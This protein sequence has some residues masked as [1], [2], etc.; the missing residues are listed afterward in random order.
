MATIQD[1]ARMSGY[2][3]GTVS[4]VINNRQGVSE[5]AR[6]KIEEVIREQGY[7]P[8]NSARMLRQSISSDITVIVRGA[9]NHFLHTILEKVQNRLREHGESANVLFIR[10]NEDE[11]AAAAQAIQ[12]LKPKGLIFLGGSADAFGGGFDKINVP[13]VLITAG[14]EGLGFDNLSSFT[15]DDRAAGA[16]VMRTLVSHGHRRIAI[17]GGY[18]GDVDASKHSSSP[19]TLRIRGAIQ[20]LEASGISFDPV[21]DYEA[22]P[23]ST[24]DGYEAARR[25]L[26]RTPDLTALF[27]VGDAV[28]IGALRA[29]YDMGL[30]V[31]DDL[32]IVGFDGVII[33]KYSI[34]RL[35]TIQQDAATLAQR[36]VDD[37]LMRLSY[38]R[39]PVHEKIPYLFIQGESI[40]SPR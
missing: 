30:T 15:T 1:I 5:S 21:R 35:A 12:N 37:L 22:C 20:E 19:G 13:S 11:V 23:F 40:A 36:G 24:P 39:P 9:N 33:T 34:P 38:D 16:F 10:E 7:Q 25:I 31:P 18:P 17:L 8:N 28:A 3:I 6:E 4:R 29:I 2:S 26:E 32:S 27:A 14:A